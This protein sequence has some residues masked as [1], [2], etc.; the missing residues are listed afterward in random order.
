[1]PPRYMSQTATIS[2]F[3]F[4]TISGFFF[5]LVENDMSKISV[6]IAELTILAMKFRKE[7]TAVYKL[8][9]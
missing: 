2:D 6:Q 7:L 5:L 3:F 8:E 1:M 9:S 4:L